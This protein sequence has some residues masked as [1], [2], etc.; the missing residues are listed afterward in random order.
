MPD[1]NNID[2][3]QLQ[4]ECKELQSML[5][6]FSNKESDALLCLEALEHI[7]KQVMSGE[8]M[9]QYNKIPC[10]YYF[11]EGTLRQFPELEEA[12]SSFT[13]RLRGGNESALN[14]FFKK[15]EDEQ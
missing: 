3:K 6:K 11:H 12:Y 8:I 13:F 15:L 5:I 7:F 4:K 2:L 14:T 1:K 10:D 9:T